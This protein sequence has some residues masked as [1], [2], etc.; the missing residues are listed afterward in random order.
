MTS[1][2]KRL[3]RRSLLAAAAAAT[4]APAAV[5]TMHQGRPALVLKGDRAGLVV[6]LLGGSFVD[7]RLASKDLNPLVWANE[8]PTGE[9]RSMSHFLCL[10]R[11]GL[12]SEAEKANGM[13]GHGEA[14]KV[15]WTT[16]REPARQGRFIE[17]ALSARLPMAGLRVERTVRLSAEGTAFHVEETVTN[18]NKLGRIYNMVQHPTVG[19]PFLDEDTVVDS[20]ARQGFM[21]SSPMPN[22]EHPTVVWPQALQGAQPVDLRRLHDDPLPNVVSYVLDEEMGWVTA[23]SPSKGLLVG[24]VW[25]TAEYPWLSMWRHVADSKPLARGLEFGTT[26]LHQPYGIL[27]EKGRIFGRKLFDHLDTGESKTR[28]FTGFLAEIPSDFQGV[29]KVT[30]DDRKATI[31]PLGAGPAIEVTL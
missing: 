15:P 7:F 31:L 30:A 24:Y 8:G 27:V 21:Q 5:K 1:D 10:D 19:P 6:D 12:P 29:Q 13:P 17:A 14:T 16:L 18:E 20:N 28:S 22:P 3:T 9:A 23:A 4:A 11:W 25:K 2:N 26:G